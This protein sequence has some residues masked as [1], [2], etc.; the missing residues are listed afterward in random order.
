MKVISINGKKVCVTDEV[1]MVFIKSE[2]KERYRNDELKN[3]KFLINPQN[4]AVKRILSREDSYD[5]LTD[6]CNLE[7]ADKSENTEDKAI[8]TMLIDKLRD[9]VM[10]LSDIEKHIIYGL[11]FQGKTAKRI[12]KEL[13]VS[14]QAIYQR[15]HNILKKLRKIIE[16]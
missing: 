8:T 14:V 15:K 12:S 10:T 1:Y 9:A 4:G 13:G 5:R 16:K 11:F 2:R 7:F 3:D 6:D